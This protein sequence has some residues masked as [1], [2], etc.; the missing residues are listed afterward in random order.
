LLKEVDKGLEKQLKLPKSLREEIITFLQDEAELIVPSRIPE[1]V[2]RDPD[3]VKILGLGLSCRAS[4]IVTGD[5]DLLVIKIFQNIPILSV[6][7]FWEFIK[8]QQKL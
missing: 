5:K 1:N 2:C 7:E 3:D 8:N 4:A 6:R